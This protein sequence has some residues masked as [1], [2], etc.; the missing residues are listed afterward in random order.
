VVINH[1]AK[2]GLE[3]ATELAQFETAHVAALKQVIEKEHIDCNFHITRAVDA[4]LDENNCRAVK[5]GYDGLVT[6]GVSTVLDVDFTLGSTA[7]RVTHFA[8][9]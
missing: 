4:Q 5:A 7:E 3:A 1:A 9:T 8:L 2:Y 6:A